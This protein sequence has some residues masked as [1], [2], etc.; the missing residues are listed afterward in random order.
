MEKSP[1]AS[2]KEIGRLKTSNTATIVLSETY[3]EGKLVGYNI[4]KWIDT[5]DFTGFTK[6]I[7]IPKDLLTNFLYIFPKDDLDLASASITRK[8]TP[9]LDKTPSRVRRNSTRKE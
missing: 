3:R 1:R 2:F 9:A 8:P 4:N 6:G 7:F 5:K